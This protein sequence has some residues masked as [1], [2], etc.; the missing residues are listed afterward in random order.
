L[1]NAV[2]ALIS[3]G[4]FERPLRARGRER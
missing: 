3:A 1:A 2:E 4:T